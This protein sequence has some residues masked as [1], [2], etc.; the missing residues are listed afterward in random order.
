M[1]GVDDGLEV[2]VGSAVQRQRLFSATGIRRQNDPLVQ[3]EV[4]GVVLLE[5]REVRRRRLLRERLRV[6]AHVRLHLL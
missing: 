4:R 5:P 3:G 1:G 2:V 6:F